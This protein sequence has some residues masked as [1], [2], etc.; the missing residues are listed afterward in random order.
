MEQVLH[1]PQTS[2]QDT[3][4]AAGAGILVHHQAGPGKQQHMQDFSSVWHFAFKSP[5]SFPKSWGG[6]K[7][8]YNACL[9]TLTQLS[10]A[11]WVWINSPVSNPAAHHTYRDGWR[12]SRVLCQGLHAGHGPHLP[13]GAQVR[14]QNQRQEWFCG[15]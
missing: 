11:V 10:Q 3:T 15:V 1:E 5:P 4:P 14:A 7:A 12:W 9:E 2:L 8:S 6:L 13:A